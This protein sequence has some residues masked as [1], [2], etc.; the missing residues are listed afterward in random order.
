MGFWSWVGALTLSWVAAATLLAIAFSR[1]GRR[2][3]RKPPFPF[4]G[5]GRRRGR[6]KVRLF[7]LASSGLHRSDD[8]FVV[9][10]NRWRANLGWDR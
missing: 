1:A 6:R 8:W 9:F 5:K 2:I 4:A 10:D 7:S 3:F